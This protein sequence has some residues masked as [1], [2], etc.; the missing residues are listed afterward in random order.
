MEDMVVT[1][2]RTEEPAKEFPGRVEVITR[3]QLK[4]MPVQT[5]DEALSYISGVHQERTSGT[6]SFPPPCPCAA[7]A[8]IRGAPLFCSTAFPS[9]RPTPEA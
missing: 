6:N 7:S 2:T 1:A 8:M 3:E 9:T 4:E 5:V